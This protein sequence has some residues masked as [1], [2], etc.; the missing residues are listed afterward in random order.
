MAD[1]GFDGANVDA[2][3]AKDV[4]NCASL[5]RIAGCCASSVTLEMGVN[6]TSRFR[7]SRVQG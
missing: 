2:L 7:G 6:T 4:A 1:I 3:V 5:N